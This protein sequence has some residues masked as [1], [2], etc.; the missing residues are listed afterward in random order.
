MNDDW[1]KRLRDI[2]ALTMPSANPF[3]SAAPVQANPFGG[4]PLPVNPFGGPTPYGEVAE[5]V[6]SSAL[7][8][9]VTPVTVRVAYLALW[10]AALA[11]LVS[12]AMG[13]VWLFDLRDNVDRALHLD[14]SGTAM[15]FAS[16]YADDIQFW[17][18]SV[19]VGVGLICAL[20]YAL[21]GWAVRGGHRW[22][23]WVSTV[24][25]LLSL[26]LLFAGPMVVMVLFGVAAVIAMWTPTARQFARETAAGRRAARA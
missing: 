19:A 21:I 23:L 22:P 25:A 8:P 1:S 24:L 4:P 3:G 16:G 18:V 17:F 9:S 20:A 10:I 26:P 11:A 2:D 5:V 6:A 14:P 7:R 12:A 15:A 13:V